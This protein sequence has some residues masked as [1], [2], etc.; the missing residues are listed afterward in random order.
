[1]STLR[2]RTWRDLPLLEEVSESLREALQQD[3]SLREALL[4][5]MLPDGRGYARSEVPADHPYGRRYSASLKN[6]RVFIDF[7]PP[8]RISVPLD[9]PPGLRW[10][11]RERELASEQEFP[12]ATPTGTNPWWKFW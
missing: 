8:G 10:I 5:G 11:P 12:R 9:E 4:K 3:A 2:N 7:L 6:G 1:M